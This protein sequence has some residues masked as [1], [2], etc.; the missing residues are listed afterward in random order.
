MPAFSYCRRLL[1]AGL[2][3]LTSSAAGAATNILV[4]GDSLSAGYG[5]A[6]MPPGPPC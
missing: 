4:F 1:L 6:R 2:M 5:I 3:L